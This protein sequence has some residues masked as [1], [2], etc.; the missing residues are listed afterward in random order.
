MNKENLT[1]LTIKLYSLTLLFPKKE[2]LRYKIRE[3]A[4]E[5]FTNYLRVNNSSDYK[6]K[7]N[8]IKGFENPYPQV[9]ESLEMLDALLE[10]A[11]V[12]NWVSPSEILNLQ[13]EYNKI[14]KD[15][16]IPIQL[17]QH[18]EIQGNE[19][20]RD[21]E[22]IRL[23][24]AST[25]NERQRKILEILK[26]KERVQSWELKRI[27]PE[28]SKRTIRRDFEHLL[29]QGLIAR[30]GEKNDTFYQLRVGQNNG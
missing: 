6:N 20:S 30:I 16:E 28:V 21:K 1:Q 24:P 4:D 14:R 27:I 13:D 11:K 10:I 12:Q 29:R 19:N 26:E 22:V 3:L 17:P 23:N 5:I 9:L 2:P 15:I 18:Y 8:P 7:G 25:I